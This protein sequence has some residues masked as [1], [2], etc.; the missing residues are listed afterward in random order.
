MR[1]PKKK[2]KGRGGSRPGAGRKPTGAPR[3]ETV[4][5]RFVPSDLASIDRAAADLGE[6]R[7]DFVRAAVLRRVETVR[8]NLGE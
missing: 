5:I 2:S 6:T 8:G 4:A 7:S 1:M 3:A